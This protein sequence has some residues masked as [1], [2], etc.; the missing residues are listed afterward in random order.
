MITREQADQ[1]IGEWFEKNAKGQPGRY[2]GPKFLKLSKGLY[3][4]SVGNDKSPLE[5]ESAGREIVVVVDAAAGWV[6]DG[7]G[8]G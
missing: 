3:F 7:G 6:D 4:Y 5:P 2:A 1:I 8:E